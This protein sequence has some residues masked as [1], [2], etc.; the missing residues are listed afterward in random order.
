MTHDTCNGVPCD[1]LAEC[2]FI[3]GAGQVKDKDGEEC[4][5]EGDAR[6]MVDGQTDVEATFA[7]V[8]EVGT[9]GNGNEKAMQ[10]IVTA[11]GE[12]LNAPAAC[13][14]G[15]V[16]DDALLVV[17]FITDEE[18]LGSMGDPTSWRDALVDAKNGDDTAM[19]VLGLVADGDV[20]GGT[21]PG[22][23]G[24][25]TLRDWTESFE[26]GSWAS[27]CEADYA[28]YFVDAVSVIDEACD[29]FEP[30]G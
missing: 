19:V 4:G 17:T 15:F 2:D 28:P 10:S 5:I 30:A 3:L 11:V 26:Y 23:V 18:D 8:A 14:D 12:D 21:C 22:P 25:P 7:C 20:Q 13:N 24:A 6:F 1:Q 29:A 9:H 16:R 27:V